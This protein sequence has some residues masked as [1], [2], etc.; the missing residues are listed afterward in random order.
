M[1]NKLIDIA[2]IIL[3]VGLGIICITTAYEVIKNPDMLNTNY[4]VIKENK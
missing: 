4:V 1:L 2:M 3:F